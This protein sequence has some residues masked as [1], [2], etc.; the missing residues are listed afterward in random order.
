MFANIAAI[1]GQFYVCV[2]VSFFGV[3]CHWLTRLRSPCAVFNEVGHRRSRDRKRGWGVQ[4][5]RERM[6]YL[7]SALWPTLLGLVFDLGYHG[8][9]PE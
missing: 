6:E 3:V 8:D 1:Y 7:A 2:C 9:L 4:K 5:G